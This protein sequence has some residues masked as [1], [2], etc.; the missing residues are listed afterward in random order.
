MCAANLLVFSESQTPQ[1]SLNVGDSN[2][3][4]QSSKIQ[5]FMANNDAVNRV[6]YTSRPVE[7]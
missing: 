6:I 2:K 7:E 1:N 3:I 4:D 5:C